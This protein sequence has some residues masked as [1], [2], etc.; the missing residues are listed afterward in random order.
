[1]FKQTFGI[2]KSAFSGHTE[3]NK[4]GSGIRSLGDVR[5]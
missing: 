2:F 5:I 1:M 4:H 3:N